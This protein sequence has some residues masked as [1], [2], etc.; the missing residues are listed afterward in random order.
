MVSILI[1]STVRVS[2]QQPTIRRDENSSIWFPVPGERARAHTA[3]SRWLRYLSS[4]PVKKQD[5]LEFQIGSAK[6]SVEITTAAKIVL[7]EEAI[8]AMRRRPLE[9]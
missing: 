6:L 5:V 4:D 1:L 2:L 3:T 8:G 7:E 9:Q